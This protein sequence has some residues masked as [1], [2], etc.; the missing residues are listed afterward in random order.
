LAPLTPRGPEQ[1]ADNLSAL[2]LTLTDEQWQRLD[3]VSA[4]PLPDYP[5]GF[6]DTMKG[7]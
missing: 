1:P 7:R 4:P 2:E 3:E 5:Y 6:M